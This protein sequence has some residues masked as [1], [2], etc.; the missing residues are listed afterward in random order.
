MLL[1]M[2]GPR[3][4]IVALVSPDLPDLPDD[5]IRRAC[6]DSRYGRIAFVPAAVFQ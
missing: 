1:V 4:T 6:A 5:P 2:A 3:V